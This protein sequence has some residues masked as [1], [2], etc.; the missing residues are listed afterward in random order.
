MANRPISGQ[1]LLRGM[2]ISDQVNNKRCWKCHVAKEYRT[3]N[4]ESVGWTDGQAKTKMI[5]SDNDDNLLYYFLSDS[6]DS[7]GTPEVMQIQ[8]VDQGSHHQHVR[9]VVGGVPMEG[10]V[11]SG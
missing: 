11:G 7:E 5:K 10:V 9:V 6:S 1:R 2:I 3:S 4:Q 8:L